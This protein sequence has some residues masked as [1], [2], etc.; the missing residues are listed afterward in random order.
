MYF[1]KF[2]LPCLNNLGMRIGPGGS[3]SKQPRLPGYP[4]PPFVPPQPPNPPGFPSAAPSKPKPKSKDDKLGSGNPQI[5]DDQD[6]NKNPVLKAGLQAVKDAKGLHADAMKNNSEAQLAGNADHVGA[7]VEAVPPH[8]D[9][10][11]MSHFS[12]A[13]ACHSDCDA[14]CASFA[15]SADPSEPA[16]SMKKCTCGCCADGTGLVCW[17]W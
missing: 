12:T 14:H 9:G 3:R 8:F 2:K 11:L 15:A 4:P 1:F 6:P 13:D 10:S 5:P 16:H 7:R 17:T